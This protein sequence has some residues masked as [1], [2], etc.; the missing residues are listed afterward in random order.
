MGVCSYISRPFLN[1]ENSIS[2]KR[3]SAF[4]PFNS[5]IFARDIAMGHN[6][7]AI[8][9]QVDAVGC[10][11]IV[12][13][14]EKSIGFPPI[15]AQGQGHLIIKSPRIGHFHPYRYQP[16]TSNFAVFMN[17]AGN[18]CTYRKWSSRSHKELL[19]WIRFPRTSMESIWK[20]LNGM[21]IRMTN[22]SFT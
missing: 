14:D 13:G 3:C 2:L 19:R 8:Y 16:I 15:I 17:T 11:I 6:W 18:P 22:G 9:L 7:T 5:Y 10:F 12:S 4:G 1:P 20:W 21:H